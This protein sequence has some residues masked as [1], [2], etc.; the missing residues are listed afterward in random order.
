LAQSIVEVHGHRAF[1]AP[2][3][4]VHLL[5]ED[6]YFYCGG[7]FG[8]AVIL[9]HI[10]GE[11]CPLCQKGPYLI[12]G[13]VGGIEVGPAGSFWLRGSEQGPSTAFV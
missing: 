4:E 8:G 11:G 6:Y 13:V 5:T 3:E 12:P 9:H 2:Q 1:S 10:R 7:G